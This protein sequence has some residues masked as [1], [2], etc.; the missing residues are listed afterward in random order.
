M[1]IMLGATGYTKPDSLSALLVSTLQLAKKDKSITHDHQFFREVRNGYFDLSKLNNRYQLNWEFDEQE[2][3]RQHDALGSFISVQGIVNGLRNSINTEGSS[4]IP[5]CDFVDNILAQESSTMKSISTSKDISEANILLRRWLLLDDGFCIVAMQHD[6]KKQCQYLVGLTLFWA[7]LFELYLEIEHKTDEYSSLYKIL[8]QIRDNNLVYSAEVFL[9]LVKQRW[10]LE[11]YQKPSISW[12]T[13]FRDIARKQLSDSELITD[14]SALPENSLELL[15]PN[16]SSTKKRFTRWRSVQSI[17]KCSEMRS[18][19]AILRQS[20]SE[21]GLHPQ[22]QWY[23]LI[24]LF[25]LMQKKLVDS[26]FEINLI[27]EEFQKFRLLKKQILHH[28]KKA[29]SERHDINNC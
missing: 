29:L 17:F 3:L 14:G 21:T 9:T 11:T 24:N 19:I 16:T 10:A 6:K 22:L 28:Y 7:S 4:L 18:H 25:S 8:P 1:P 27:H 5:F 26:G 13:L 12:T 2:L 15:E 23:F 20:Y